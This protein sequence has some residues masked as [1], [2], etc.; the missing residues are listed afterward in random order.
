[1]VL[2]VDVAVVVVTVV[3]VA[4][5][6]VTV[7]AVAVVVVVDRGLRGCG[8]G[9]GGLL[10]KCARSGR[11]SDDTG[12]DRGCDQDSCTHFLTSVV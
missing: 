8:G 2:A 11:H 6:V 1:M 3:A 4:V 12:D 5:V 7:V 9:R 10:R